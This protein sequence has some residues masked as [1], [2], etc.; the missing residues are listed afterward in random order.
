MSEK[1]YPGGSIAKLSVN[2]TGAPC[3]QVY[4]KCLLQDCCSVKAS[5]FRNMDAY[6]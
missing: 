6:L 3:D 2:G 4:M 5:V 1:H